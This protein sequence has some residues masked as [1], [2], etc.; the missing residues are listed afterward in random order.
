M[1]SRQGAG[2]HRRQ[3]VQICN[4]PVEGGSRK[5]VDQCA[6]ITQPSGAGCREAGGAGRELCMPDCMSQG[7][8]SCLQPK[9]SGMET[10]DWG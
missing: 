9:S 1:L 5:A 8:K 10:G 6:L 7:E 4:D 2:E 3:R